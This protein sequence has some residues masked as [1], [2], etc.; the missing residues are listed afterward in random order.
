M[1]FD[2]VVPFLKDKDEVVTEKMLL[3]FLDGYITWEKFLEGLELG[4]LATEFENKDD[5]VKALKHALV[6]KSDLRAIVCMYA[7][8]GNTSYAY[9][10]LETTEQMETFLSQ[11]KAMALH[12]VKERLLNT[13]EE[14]A[15]K[16]ASDS[17]FLVRSA[18]PGMSAASLQTAEGA[19]GLQTA[20]GETS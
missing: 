20:E 9:S 11:A 10:K 16:V 17:I 5:V 7:T 18:M 4:H 2:K 3:S 19:Y 8:Y 15:H 13:S 1:D 14:N 12:H 6:R